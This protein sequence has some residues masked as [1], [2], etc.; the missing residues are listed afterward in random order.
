M[1]H[2][3]ATTNLNGATNSS[4]ITDPV[5]DLRE[6]FLAV[7][8]PMTWFPS[9]LAYQKVY[10]SGATHYAL[11]FS[12]TRIEFPPSLV[13][14]YSATGLD[15]SVCVDRQSRLRPYGYGDQPHTIPH[16]KRLAAVQW[17]N[18]NWGV[19]QTQ[20][21][22][23]NK[24]RYEVSHASQDY[25]LHALPQKPPE[26][27][28]AFQEKPRS[29][30]PSG[31]QPKSRSAVILRA[32]HDMDWSENTKQHVRSL[33]MELSLHSGGEYEVFILS[34]IRDKSISLSHADD[35][36]ILKLKD[37]FIPREFHNITVLFNDQILESWY[38]N[39]EEHR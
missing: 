27:A 28:D 3:Q 19:L 11:M 38:P 37:R 12:H 39:I 26:S 20:C 8:A 9:I 21:Y 29:S 18:A 16:P 35:E 1:T 24:D 25:T 14:S 31:Q 10:L 2:I 30:N 7:I 6:T 13:G 34:H 33:I 32:W 17:D 5:K 22:L 15:G 4:E 23:R 36:Y